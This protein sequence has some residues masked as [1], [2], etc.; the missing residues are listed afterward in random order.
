MKIKLL[1][2]NNEVKAI[3]WPNEE[4]YP[5]IDE[6]TLLGL[7]VPEI[8][9]DCE[10]KI[11]NSS[12]LESLEGFEDHEYT[13]QLLIAEDELSVDTNK[14]RSLMPVNL[15]RK[16]YLD[17]LKSLIESELEKEDP[18]MGVINLNQAK[19]QSC[20]KWDDKKWYEQA[21]K[22]LD[23]RVENGEPDKEIIREKL[24]EKINELS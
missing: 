3:V 24:Q 2:L 19:I 22:N 18:D 13:E 23:T 12:E 15:I 4:L 5:D 9:Q 1:H 6:E 21:L 14:E 16:K 8:F 20:Q 7:P 10:Q 17:K 11:I